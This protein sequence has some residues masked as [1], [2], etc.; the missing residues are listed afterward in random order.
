MT[1]S[2]KEH[3]I[4]INET[5]PG[6]ATL[7]VRTLKLSD[8]RNY[9]SARLDLDAR[10]VVLAGENGSGKTNLLEAVSLLGPGHGL[11]GRPYAELAR[12][13]GQG[14][15]AIAASVRTRHGELDIGTGYTPRAGDDGTGRTVRIA[16][17]DASAGALGD[18]VKQV[19]LIPAMD[20]LFTG[21]GSERR[22]FLDR[23]VV[24]IAPG[25]RTS[26]SRYERAMRQRNR[27]FQMREHGK[28]LFEGLEEQM[29]ESGVAIAAARLDAVERLSA[30][31]DE[32]RESEDQT[33]FPHAVLALHGTVEADLAERSATEAEDAFRILLEEGR[34]RD[35]AASRTLEGPHRSDLLVVHGP[36]NAPAAICSS[37]EQK[38]LLLGLVLAKAELIKTLEGIAP[39]VLLDEVAAHLDGVRREALFAEIL[40]LKVQAWMTGTDKELFSP[41]GQSAQIL[42]V[43]RGIISA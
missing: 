13:D 28:S 4:K 26:L 29:A 9:A 38:A 36:K 17:K 3:T 1:A 35:R 34:E 33:P 27:L 30:L 14:G 25:L 18:Y 22:R 42:D 10:P 15:F 12:K 31:I 19:F 2:P 6:T 16:G 20:G 8:F 39:L 21:P 37:G 23:L 11:R 43:N 40:R 32:R 24:A 41:L 7:S 5:E